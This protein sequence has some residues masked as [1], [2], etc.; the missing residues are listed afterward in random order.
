MLSQSLFINWIW[1]DNMIEYIV[2]TDENDAA[3]KQNALTND[4]K[5]RQLNYGVIN[6]N[7]LL[8]DFVK[9]GESS[10]E[11]IIITDLDKMGDVLKDA[12]T[13]IIKKLSSTKE[14]YIFVNNEEYTDKQSKL[15]RI[16]NE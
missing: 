10:T 13:P 7:S 5:N 6:M 9:L 11:V 8:G 1:G 14:V 2:Y 15:L 12:I 4:I 16:N 3:D